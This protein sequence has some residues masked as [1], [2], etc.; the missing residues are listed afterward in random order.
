[1]VFTRVL[2]VFSFQASRQRMRAMWEVLGLKETR[3]QFIFQ[4]KYWYVSKS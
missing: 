4:F 1:M 2:L 3:N